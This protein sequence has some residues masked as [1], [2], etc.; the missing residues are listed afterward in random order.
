MQVRNEFLYQNSSNMH[1]KQQS[2]SNIAYTHLY[3]LLKHLLK[4]LLW[5]F[6]RLYK[7]LLSYICIFFGYLYNNILHRILTKGMV[8]IDLTFDFTETLGH[9]FPVLRNVSPFDFEEFIEI[10]LAFLVGC[11]YI[12][13][14]F[15]AQTLIG[16]YLTKNQA[17]KFTYHLLRSI[18]NHSRS[19]SNFLQRFLSTINLRSK[20]QAIDDVKCR[21]KSAIWTLNDMKPKKKQKGLDKY[22]YPSTDN[23][24]KSYSSFGSK[25][26]SNIP[27]SKPSRKINEP[28]NSQ[29]LEE[30]IDDC[31][32]FKSGYDFLRKEK[33]HS[34]STIFTN[35]IMALKSIYASF[36]LSYQNENS[37][38][39]LKVLRKALLRR[40]RRKKKKTHINTNRNMFTFESQKALL[41]QINESHDTLNLI[42]K[43]I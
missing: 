4:W 27:L 19:A 20:Y 33:L 28:I 35:P 6:Y 14:W 1:L 5:Y 18:I 11:Y 22:G 13:A 42:N 15:F 37:E 43:Q 21:P 7:H 16:W 29:Q 41:L 40:Q 24:G 2:I 26:A 32:M 3:F 34:F 30:L 10:Y 25:V 39:N 23:I 36:L 9:S 8:I 17:C 38:T 12:I 31:D